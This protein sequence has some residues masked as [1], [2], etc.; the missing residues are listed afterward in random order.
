M[1]GFQITI[2]NKLFQIH[3]STTLKYIIENLD[4]KYY[5]DV[6]VIILEVILCKLCQRLSFVP[7]LPIPNPHQ[8]GTKLGVV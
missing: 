3:Q 8:M 7:N 1:K 5:I 4:L 6:K 2:F